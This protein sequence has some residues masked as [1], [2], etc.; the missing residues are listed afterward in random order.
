MPSISSAAITAA[1]AC[2]DACCLLPQ[3]PLKVG[4]Q[5]SWA[6]GVSLGGIQLI[7]YCTY[8]VAFVYGADR[9]AAGK[10]TGEQPHKNKTMLWRCTRV[11]GLCVHVYV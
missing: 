2:T 11:P 9:V 8:A 10:Y 3:I 6:N 7:M 1:V 4:L 5:Q